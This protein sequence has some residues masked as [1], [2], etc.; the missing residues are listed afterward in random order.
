MR[1]TWPGGRKASKCPRQVSNPR[2]R[3]R[4]LRTGQASDLPKAPSPPRPPPPGEGKL[5]VA[6]H[7]GLLTRPGSKVGLFWSPGPQEPEPGRSTRPAGK[8]RVTSP[9]SAI[10]L[11]HPCPRPRTL[12]NVQAPSHGQCCHWQGHGHPDTTSGSTARKVPPAA[13]AG[14]LLPVYQSPAPHA[15]LGSPGPLQPG[16]DHGGWAVCATQ[17]P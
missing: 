10:D 14:H 7:A 16:P 2:P 11:R 17:C 6:G 1:G 15:V 4:T 9:R 13:T 5:R 8:A 3:P 12:G